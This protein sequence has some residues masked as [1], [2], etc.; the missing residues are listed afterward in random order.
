MPKWKKS[1]VNT[2]IHINNI[3]HYFYDCLH[4]V[5][6]NIFEMYIL[7][8][9]YNLYTL[10]IWLKPILT[11]INWWLAYLKWR[12]FWL[13]EQVFWSTCSFNHSKKLFYK[14]FSCFNSTAISTHI[15]M[16]ELFRTNG[17]CILHYR[18]LAFWKLYTDINNCSL[19]I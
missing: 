1:I 10:L 17:C 7:F 12:F 19:Q 11:H 16:I 4:I 3:L 15:Y 18:S 14:W 5:N 2:K 13:I 6:K 8:F 9:G